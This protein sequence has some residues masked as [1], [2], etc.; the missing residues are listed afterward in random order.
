M[1][2]I[3]VKKICRKFNSKKEDINEQK[4]I[5]KIILIDLFK[6]WNHFGF[7]VFEATWE[8]WEGPFLGTGVGYLLCSF[9]LFIPS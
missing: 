6:I 3:I 9:S 5:L 8:F 2:N 1:K 7:V 4:T